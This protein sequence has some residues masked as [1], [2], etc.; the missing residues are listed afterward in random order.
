MIY[1]RKLFI[2]NFLSHSL[3]KTFINN[4]GTSSEVPFIIVFVRGQRGEDFYK[5]SS[6]L[7]IKTN[8]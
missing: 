2:K 5:K 6:P 7:D 8:K 4:Q 3:S 1:E